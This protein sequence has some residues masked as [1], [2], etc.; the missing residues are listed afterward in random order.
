MANSSKKT[1]ILLTNLKLLFLFKV[2][3]LKKSAIQ[4]PTFKYK[5]TYTNLYTTLVA[6][7][8]SLLSYVQTATPRNDVII[9]FFNL[10]NTYSL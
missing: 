6:F 8:N 10:V 1:K 5:L 7:S 3:T 9:N 2:R 4:L